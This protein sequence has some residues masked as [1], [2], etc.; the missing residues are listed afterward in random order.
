MPDFAGLAQLQGRVERVLNQRLAALGAPAD[1]LVPMRYA[2]LGG[3][4]RLRAALVYAAGAAL[5]APEGLLDDAACAVELIHAY[6]LVHD[7]L[8]AMDN[9]DFRR[10]K[11]TCHRQFGEAAALLAG[12]ALQT[13]AFET[14]AD[15]PEPGRLRM[16]RRL[17]RAAG[18]EGMAGG[19]AL[20]LAQGAADLIG[21]E[22]L[23]QRKT[24]ALI[25]VSVVLGGEA[26]DAG[27]AMLENLE[28][29]GRALGLA[30]QIRDDLLDADSDQAAAAAR[31]SYVALLGAEQARQRLAALHAQALASLRPLG[32]NGAVLATLADFAVRREV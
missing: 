5:G 17:A 25:A 23:H 21:I 10:G 12:D 20:D 31:P 6:S 29:Y 14:L 15:G 27:M 22:A 11:P 18:A 19:Q 32:D 2:S 24:G 26:A 8:P 13:L 16:V 30:F 3:G 1:L 9:D 28:A 4:K 7:D